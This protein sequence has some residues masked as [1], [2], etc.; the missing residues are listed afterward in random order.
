MQLI[1]ILSILL[2]ISVTL[3]S[4]RSPREEEWDEF[5]K[6]HQDPEQGQEIEWDVDF[7]IAF[8]SNLKRG[9]DIPFRNPTVWDAEVEQDHFFETMLSPEWTEEKEKYVALIFRRLDKVHK[10]A[11]KNTEVYE[12]SES[13]QFL[14]H[15]YPSAQQGEKQ[16]VF[17]WVK[18][19]F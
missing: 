7:L 8:W 19:R 16:V 1:P 13:L 17:F 12:I 9:E 6:A 10:S 4:S 18:V 15:C 14:I 2:L 3:S 11:L 5:L